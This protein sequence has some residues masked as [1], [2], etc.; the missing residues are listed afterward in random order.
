MPRTV[1][2]RRDDRVD[3]VGRLRSLAEDWSGWV[4]F[5]PQVEADDLMEAP[6]T[7]GLFSG[8]GPAV[9]E[10]SWV[11]E[12]ATRRRARRLSVGLRHPTGPKTADRLAA[13]GH[14]VP[15]DWTVVD[16]SP[17]RGLVVRV[18]LDVDQGVLLEWL[19]GAAERCTAV[20]LTGNWRATIHRYL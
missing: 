13:A 17:K 9:P 19:L 20:P 6:A 1:E 4:I 7:G 3:M 14:A 8:R 5:D 2:F 15:D 10:L 11:P 18:P 12:P 16:D